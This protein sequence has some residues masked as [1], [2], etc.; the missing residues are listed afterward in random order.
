MKVKELCLKLMTY[1]QCMY[2]KQ[3]SGENKD[4]MDLKHKNMPETEFFCFPIRNFYH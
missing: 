3:A 1:L 4:L 2:N